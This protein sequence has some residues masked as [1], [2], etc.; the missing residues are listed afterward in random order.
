M[1]KDFEIISKGLILSQTSLGGKC[2]WLSITSPNTR[3]SNR[4]GCSWITASHWQSRT[5]ADD[6]KDSRHQR[7]KYEA[8]PNTDNYQRHQQFAKGVISLLLP[9]NQAWS[10]L[11]HLAGSIPNPDDNFAEVEFA[12]VHLVP[13]W[14]EHTER[15]SSPGVPDLCLGAILTAPFTPAQLL[16]ARHVRDSD[17]RI[18]PKTGQKVK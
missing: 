1:H 6:C 8:A 14:Q 16:K 10:S 18:C 3:S 13:L 9:P 12:L 17:T 11:Y 4:C 15:V 7:P 5:P 2:I